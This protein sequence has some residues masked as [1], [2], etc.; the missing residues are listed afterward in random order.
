MMQTIQ[1]TTEELSQYR[2]LAEHLD[3]FVAGASALAEQLKR[4]QVQELIQSRRGTQETKAAAE[5][6]PA[7]ESGQQEHK[8]GQ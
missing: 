3:G 1:L 4:K 8:N 7:P 2:V 5:P 6:G